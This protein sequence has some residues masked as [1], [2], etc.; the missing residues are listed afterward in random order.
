MALRGHS[1]FKTKIN[2]LVEQWSDLCVDSP[3][4]TGAMEDCDALATVTPHS[5]AVVKLLGK[6]Q[7]VAK[8][9]QNLSGGRINHLPKTLD[10]AGPSQDTWTVQILQEA[11]IVRFLTHFYSFSALANNLLG[12]KA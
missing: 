12:D 4:S 9:K 11:A 5:G 10:D 1:V 8:Q 7:N 2:T 6:L 3:S